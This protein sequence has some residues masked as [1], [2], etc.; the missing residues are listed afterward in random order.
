MGRWFVNRGPTLVFPFIISLIC[1]L[2]GGCNQL[3]EITSITAADGS[4]VADVP[5]VKDGPVVS[6][7]PVV[8][9]GPVMPDVS[10]MADVPVLKDGGVDQ[11][12]DRQATGGN[13]FCDRHWRGR[14]TGGRH[15]RRPGH[16]LEHPEES[17]RD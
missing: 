13:N 14:R 5:V 12:E 16:P 3:L 1:G 4:V 15:R 10:V 6:D 7:V 2:A 17:G 8:K 9:D 11:A